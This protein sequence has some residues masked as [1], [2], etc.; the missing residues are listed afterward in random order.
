MEL[1][2]NSNVSKDLQHTLRAIFKWIKKIKNNLKKR[3]SNHSIR[4]VKESVCHLQ[5]PP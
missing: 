5:I 4:G 3:Y 2:T 1:K